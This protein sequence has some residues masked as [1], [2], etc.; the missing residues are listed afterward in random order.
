MENR[1][2]NGTY[3]SRCATNCTYITQLANSYG[4]A[5]NYSGVAHNSLPNYLSLTSAGNYSYAP[6]YNDCSPP[7]GTANMT[8]PAITAPNLVDR[9]DSS[10][11]TWKAYMEDYTGGGCS[12]H[13]ATTLTSDKNPTY[14]NNHNPFLYYS[15]VYTNTTR[16]TNIVNANPG[17][18][19]YLALPTVL[20]SDLNRTAAPNFMWLSPNQCDD[21][22]SPCN[23]L[24]NTV[25][26]ANNYLS[27][28]VPKILASPVFR[29]MNSSLF[30]VWDE[31]DNCKSPG[32][33][34]PTCIDLVSSLWAGPIVKAG[35][36]SNT[37]YSH[38]SFLKTLEM[39]WN[40]LPLTRFDTA[41]LSMTE[42][43]SPP[44]V[45]DGLAGS[46]EKLLAPLSQA[47]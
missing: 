22:H 18:T 40:F 28:L 12:R 38:Y 14:V 3:G 6:Y 43:F 8:C 19:G 25:L 26:Q 27:L 17:I 35:Y 24:N 47:T 44:F 15:D 46:S 16:C 5:E 29:E 11:R 30:I 21:G 39:A 36:K 45:H 42:F 9:I 2:I 13:G 4:L 7:G 1:G 31:G 10:G 23:P 33:T 41:A 37:G 20:L 32:Q 34:Y